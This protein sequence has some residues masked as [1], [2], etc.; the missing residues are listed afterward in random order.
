MGMGALRQIKLVFEQHFIL[1]QIEAEQREGFGERPAPENN[2]RPAARSRI[3]GRNALKQ[4][5]R[6]VRTQHCDRGA[7]MNAARLPGDCGKH[8]FWRGNRKIGAMMFADAKEI[9]PDLIGQHRFGDNVADHL[10]MRRSFAP[11]GPGFQGL[12]RLNLSSRHRRRHRCVARG[13]SGRLDRA[14]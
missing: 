3:E 5:D 1:R 10:R 9:D 12:G 8:D 4:T 14:D 11:V 7:E 13:L 2:L 6:V